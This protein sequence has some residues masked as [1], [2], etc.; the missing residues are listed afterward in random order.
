MQTL[1]CTGVC[2]LTILVATLILCVHASVLKVAI[3][4]PN[5]YLYK[6]KSMILVVEVHTLVVVVNDVGGH[7]KRPTPIRDIPPSSYWLF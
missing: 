1:Q 6:T 2:K 5:F 7:A 4:W 3:V